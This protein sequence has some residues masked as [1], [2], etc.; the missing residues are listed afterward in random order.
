MLLVIPVSAQSGVE[1]GEI[2]GAQFRIDVPENWNGELLVYCHGYSRTPGAFDNPRVHERLAPFLEMG[3]AVAQ[4][5]YAAGGWAISEAVQDTE[6]LRRHFIR[7]HGKPK[8]TYVAGHSMGG[9]LTMTLL[10]GF[11][12]A[13]DGGLALC[14]P[15]AAA[16]WFMARRVFDLVVVFDYFFPGALPR[17]DHVP[18]DYV[19][20]PAV[21]A[22]LLEQL[23]RDAAKAAEVR[24]WSGIRNDQ[25]LANTVAF[26]TYIV[27]DLQQRGGG[28]PFDN[29]DIIYD[30]VSDNNALNQ[31]V[32]RFT[33]DRRAAQY[34]RAY[35]TPSG[36]I[37]R[38]M[39]AIHTTYDPLVPP[40]VPNRYETLAETAGNGERF[41]Q[42]YVRRAGHCAISGQETVQG[43]RQLKAWVE[44]G[45]P[46]EA[47]DVTVE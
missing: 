23:S 6:A 7:K 31:G 47:G 15:L 9:F 5:G 38:P 26:F 2:N 41:V 17:L 28:H 22:A 34:L 35:Y 4:S 10:E 32:K 44:S 14:G 29:R 1:T 11:P 46:P 12:D 43:L 45:A 19:N 42:Q 37:E 24:Q 16:N 36:R 3:L 27:M 21:S 8:R 13:Y 39:L 30:G 33:A 40:W 20:T 18:R 25:E